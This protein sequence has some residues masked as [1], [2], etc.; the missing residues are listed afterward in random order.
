[1]HTA[2]VDSLDGS[3]VYWVPAVTAPERDWA[4]APGCHRGA[5]FLID[6]ASCRPS[7]DNYPLFE[8]RGDCLQW[9]MAHR[10]DLTRTAPQAPVRP[11]SLA[12]WLLGLA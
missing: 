11:V 10:L 1:M 4:G 2:D 8:S 12:H 6:A 7:R 5:R 9:I 3:R